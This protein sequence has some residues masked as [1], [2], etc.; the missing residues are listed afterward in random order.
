M[1]DQRPVHEAGPPQSATPLSAVEVAEL[2][3]AWMAASAS[4]DERALAAFARAHADRLVTEV[5]RLWMALRDVADHAEADD[6]ACGRVGRVA[7][8]ALRR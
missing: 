3:E 8:A 2:G 4:D 7:R 5:G 1:S 6:C